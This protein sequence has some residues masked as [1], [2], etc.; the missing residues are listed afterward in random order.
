PETVAFADETAEAVAYFALSASSRLA[1]ERGPYSSF[2]GSKWDRGLV[3][4]DT[5]RLLEA[6]RGEAIDVDRSFTFDWDALRERIRRHGIRNSK[7][8]AIA[9]TA[10]I[11]NIV[12]VSPS[13]EPL[14]R[15]LYVKS[16]LSGDFVVV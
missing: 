2:P 3:P 13:I 10:T 9:P 12:G 16:N 15:N 5:L 1:E 8:T 11:A 6:E 14:F 7:T 4:L